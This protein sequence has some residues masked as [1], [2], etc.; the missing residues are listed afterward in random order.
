MHDDDTSIALQAAWALT[1][2]ASVRGGRARPD[3]FLGFVEGRVKHAIPLR[4]EVWLVQLCFHGDRGR[5]EAALSEYAERCTFVRKEPGANRYIVEPEVL[6]K[7]RSGIRAPPGVGLEREGDALVLGYKGKRIKISQ[8]LVGKLGDARM[9]PS[10]AAY[11]EGN[12]CFVAF[13]GQIPERFPLLC[14]DANTGRLHWRAEVWALGADN[15]PELFGPSR[16]ETIVAPE[17]GRITVYGA[18]SGGCYIESFEKKTGKVVFRF[19]TNQW[20]QGRQ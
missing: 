16:H 10:C 3:R 9:Y 1:G 20:F 4:W 11:L 7:T 6:G 8:E 12:Q 17:Q 18:G 15:L 14:I 5:Q 2:P 13:Y 19:A